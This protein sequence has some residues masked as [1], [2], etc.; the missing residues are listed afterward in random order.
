[1]REISEKE[2]L[3][4]HRFETFKQASTFGALSNDTIAWLL[5]EGCI[6][7]LNE[8]ENLFEHGDR[9]DSFFVILDGSL[10]YYKYHDGRYA[11]IR[12]YEKGQQIGFV[13]T[14]ALHDRV[15]KAVA[16]QTTVA[17]EISCSVF[18]GLHKQ[19]PT[20]FGLLMLN[21]AREMARTIRKVDNII[22]DMRDDDAA[23]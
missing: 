20:D 1:M 7:T 16:K 17:L 2:L 22:V 14:I 3:S 5:H 4:E 23:N 21:L 9:G 15:G 12:D 19:A 11:Y 8:G 18:Y 6:H 13:S 10:A